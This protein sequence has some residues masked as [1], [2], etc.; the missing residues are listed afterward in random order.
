[1][2]DLMLASDRSAIGSL[3]VTSPYDGRELD[4]LA[5]AG[6]AHVDDAL[7]AA[8]Q[9]FRRRDGWLSVPERIS[10]LDK[11]AAIMAE[12]VDELTLLAAS[13]GGKPLA[14]SKVEVIRA[15]NGVHLCVEG[16]RGDSGV[17]IP[18]G[19]TAA[20]A[21]RTAFTVKEP[22]GVVVAVSAFNH[23]LNLIVHQVAPAVASGCPVI[24][25]PAADTPLSCIRFVEILRQ[26]GLPDEWCQV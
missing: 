1:M 13:E 9:L 3:A 6:L 22:I 24:V 20:S 14:D 23:P 18:L 10:I 17:V 21:G 4:N 19:T 16:L 25:K 5:T 7:A 15:I 11:A 2:R 12:N 26:A 8:Q